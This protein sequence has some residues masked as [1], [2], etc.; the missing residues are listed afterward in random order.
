[1]QPW[2][3]LRKEHP[4]LLEG[5]SIMQQ[6]AAVLDGAIHKWRLEDLAEAA[7][8]KLH[9]RPGQKLG[10]R[11]ELRNQPS[12]LPTISTILLLLS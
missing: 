3:Q 4:E 11:V 10:F 8:A 6:P 9:A 5:I 12:L 7:E 1:M 2:V